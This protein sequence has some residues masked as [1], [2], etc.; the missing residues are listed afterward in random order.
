MAEIKLNQQT[1]KLKEG[2]EEA[3]RKYG[4]TDDV[5]GMTAL[6]N[7]G[8]ISGAR[9]IMFTSHLKQ[10]LNL[11]NP[12]FPLVNTNYENLVGR[13][14]TT[15]KKAKRDW[16][17]EDK[18]YKF[19]GDHKLYMLI[20]YDP[21]ENYYHVIQ[22]KCVENLTEKFGFRYNTENLD[23]MEVGD[24]IK[25]GDV[26]YKSS[27]YDEDDNYCY[28]KNVTFM[29]LVDSDTIEDAIKVSESIANELLSTEIETVTVSLN[30]N[31]IL[32]NIYG[33]D[34]NYKAFPDIGENTI[35]KTVCCKRRIYN[36]QLL[37][38]FK[39]SNLRK[40]DYSNDVLALCDGKI[41]DINI[42]CNKDLDEIPDNPMYNQIKAYHK[43]EIRYYTELYNKTKEIIESGAKYSRDLDYVYKKSK[44]I[45]DEHYKWRKSDGSVFNNMVIQFEVVRSVKLERGGKITGRYGNKGVVSTIT[46][47]DEMP[48][49]ENGKRVD[50]IFN[51]LGVPNRLNT[52]QLIEQ[53]INFVTGHVVK[54]LSELDSMKEKEELLF[55]IVSRFNPNQAKEM[56][57]FYKKLKPTKKDLFFEQIQQFGI[58]IH[59]QPLWEEVPI[60]DVLRKIYADY[61]W[62]QPYRVFIK[63]FGRMVPMMNK[64]VV[65]EMYVMKLKQT[66]HKNFS[67]R[68][69]GSLSKKG[70][71]EKT[72]NAKD[73]KTA[74][75]DTPVKLGIDEN[76]N[77]MICTPAEEI[78]KLH[79]FY[80]NS[81]NG[82][83]S[84]GK[85]LMTEMDT[86]EDF[87]IDETT[88]N[89]NVEILQAYFKAMGLRLAFGKETLNIEINGGQMY[90]EVVD[91]TLVIGDLDDINEHKMRAMAKE[92]INEELFVGSVEDLNNELEKKYNEIVDEV[93]ASTIMI[94]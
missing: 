90:D 27:S 17:V 9:S 33:D 89:R 13:N 59:I 57:K 25:K 14:N 6:T 92:R 84:L 52:F 16:V 62:I 69:T 48:I 5:F 81:I 54:R 30:D 63:K 83:K 66:A 58:Y 50:I 43:N 8:Y 56:K 64:M 26:L 21:E 77:L 12:D 38:D 80:R 47:D 93:G 79:M 18:I 49:L 40:I 88:K 41:T 37:Y 45:L 36:E 46:P 2:L 28:G 65:S 70:L 34:D 23:K 15:I 94:D 1:A 53:S 61:P 20:L 71:P 73:N 11:E 85:S 7:P 76:L 86:I 4:G 74:Y 3:E 32:C 19:D 35:D 82:R 68:S 31:D 29:Y 78:V 87:D 39:K 22:K 10:L 72:D 67:S 60:F 42:Y 44:E 91:G 75:K 24:E 55:D 51:V